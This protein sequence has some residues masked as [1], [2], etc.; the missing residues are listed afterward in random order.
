M[1]FTTKPPQ[2]PHALPPDQPWV[3]PKTGRLTKP[4]QDY[5]LKLAEWRK[6]LV[7]YLTAMAAAI[8]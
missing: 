1:A 3:D 7:A 6:R 2:P 5:E 8:P 4:A